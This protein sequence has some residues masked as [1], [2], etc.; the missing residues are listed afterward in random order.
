[1][2]CT[3]AYILHNIKLHLRMTCLVH[4]FRLIMI[5]FFFAQVSLAAGILLNLISDV[6]E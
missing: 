4:C 2:F 6:S 3:R 5:L 1:M